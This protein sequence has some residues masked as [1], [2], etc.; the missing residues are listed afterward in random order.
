MIFQPTYLEI[1]SYFILTGLIGFYSERKYKKNLPYSP[2]KKKENIIKRIYLGILAGI[3]YILF[4]G[5]Y[6]HKKYNTQVFYPTTLECYLGNLSGLVMEAIIIILFIIAK[7]KF[8]EI[9]NLILLIPII[10]NLIS[11]KF[12]K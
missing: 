7:F 12:K 11:L 3:H 4:I 9:A 5:T 8:G 2:S 1:A 10:T 6:N